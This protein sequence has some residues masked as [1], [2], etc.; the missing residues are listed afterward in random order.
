[1]KKDA[2]LGIDIGGTNIKIAS[3]APSGRIL[4][5][6]V[7]ETVP[8]RGPEDAFERVR[9]TLPALFR[10]DRRL[11]AAG[12]GCA[13]LVDTEKGKLLTSPNLPAWKQVPLKRIAERVLGVQTY[14]DN[15]ANA[16]AY[17][18]YKCGAGKG[19]RNIVCMTLGT[20]VGGGIVADG[21]L[22]KGATNFAGEIGHVSININGPRCKCGNRGCLEAYIGK[23][24][25]VRSALA[26]LEVKRGKV[27]GRL[28]G[29]EKRALTPK[30]IYSAALEGDRIAKQVLYEAAEYL[31]SAIAALVNVLNPEVIV[32]G[33]G[34][35]GAFDLM[36]SKV[37][38]VVHTRAFKESAALVKI[39]RAK[40][41]NDASTIGAALLAKEWAE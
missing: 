2:Y 26:K 37:E 39:T 16:A 7:I 34:I 23:D 3:V 14:I 32:I 30:M 28:T 24:A 11:A 36:K 18:E 13:G 15:D 1:M 5:H 27:L 33:G 35:S 22:L 38:K 4:S 40:L 6:S 10:G 19:Y 21:K 25:L 12:V 29:R 41:G 31:G 17:G 8:G 20:G 9:L